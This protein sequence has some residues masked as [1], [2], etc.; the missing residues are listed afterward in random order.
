MIENNVEEM[1]MLTA[2]QRAINYSAVET[3]VLENKN[4][5]K[6]LVSNFGATVISLFIF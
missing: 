3:F 4:G 2:T 6:L 5:T 1:E